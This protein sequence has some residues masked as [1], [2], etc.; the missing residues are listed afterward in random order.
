MI[1]IGSD[2]E[3][4]HFPLVS[5]KKG[6]AKFTIEVR[7]VYGFRQRGLFGARSGCVLY[8]DAIPECI[9]STPHWRKARDQD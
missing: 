4:M 9:L 5:L 7:L 6:L 2:S 8:A 3:I 1:I